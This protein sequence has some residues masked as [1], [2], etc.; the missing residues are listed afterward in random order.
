[1]ARS[2]EGGSDPSTCD[3]LVLG[4]GAGGELVATKLARAGLDVVVVES[5]LLGGECPFFGC[6]PSKLLIRSAQAVAE[7][8]R[9]DGLGGAATVVPDFD[10]PVRRIRDAT[11]QWHDDAHVDPLVDAG[12]RVVR[13]HGRLAGEGQV[14]V[15]DRARPASCGQRP[16]AWCSTPAPGPRCCRST[17]SRRR[18]TGPTERCSASRNRPHGWRSSG[19]RTDRL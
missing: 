11:H 16:G 17:G 12:V 3:V 13:G 1:M 19:R 6:T 14:E 2:E 7:A 9:A 18:R 15:R 5:R 8:R 10:I 4:V